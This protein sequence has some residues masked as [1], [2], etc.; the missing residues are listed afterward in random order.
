MKLNLPMPDNV[1]TI[2]VDTFDL[3]NDKDAKEVDAR[4]R[5]HDFG[6]MLSRLLY[7]ARVEAPIVLGI[8]FPVDA[9][10]NVLK[11]ARDERKMVQFVPVDDPSEQGAVYKYGRDREWEIAW[12]ARGLSG[13]FPERS[14]WY[15]QEV[16]IAIFREGSARDSLM[17]AQAEGGGRK[18]GT[19]SPLKDEE[20]ENLAERS[21]AAS[22]TDEFLNLLRTTEEKPPSRSKVF[23]ARKRKS[24][25]KKVS[26]NRPRP[27]N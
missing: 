5:D 14:R 22:S 7:I 2:T 21:Y 1:N 24:K 26:V 19:T 9:S 8:P 11:M 6:L 4:T 13:Y 3:F 10:S 17:L 15:W 18:R 27:I 23:R 25:K 12:L 20:Y 16:F